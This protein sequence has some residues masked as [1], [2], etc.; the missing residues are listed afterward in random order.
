MLKVNQT[1][2]DFTLPRFDG[3]D[4]AFYQDAGGGIAVLVFYKFSC[5]TCQYTMPFIQKI[6]DAYG[7]AFYFVAIAQDDAEK[8]A[9]FRK[10]YAISMPTLLDIPPYPASNKYKIDTVPSTFL[11][12]PDR[13]IRYC[14]DG[15]VKQELLN[16][17]DVLAEKSGRPQIEVFEGLHVPDFKAG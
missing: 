16:L 17:A 11:V 12:E 2:P 15:F 1:A 14:G 6:Y 3:D 8:T 13:K 7:D 4:S 10:D 5:P 9:E